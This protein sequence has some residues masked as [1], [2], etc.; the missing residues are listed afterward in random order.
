MKNSAQDPP[1]S[2]HSFGKKYILLT[3][4][5]HLSLLSPVKQKT[6]KQ[7]NKYNKKPQTNPS[8]SKSYIS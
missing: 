7:T 8:H 4:P 5:L 6:N 3:S 1:A 2:F